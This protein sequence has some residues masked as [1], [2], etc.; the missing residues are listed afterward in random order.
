[1][2]TGSIEISG[3][4]RKCGAPITSA[5]TSFCERHKKE[6]YHYYRKVERLDRT[7]DRTKPTVNDIM[8]S[9]I[10]MTDE[11]YILWKLGQ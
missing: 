1:M 5:W 9:Y 10:R 7:I 2:A 11:E 8:E 3:G 4:C 6:Y